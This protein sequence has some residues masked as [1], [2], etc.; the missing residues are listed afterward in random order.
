M[1]ALGISGQTVPGQNSPMP[2]HVS[3]SGHSTD[4][5]WRT[6]LPDAALLS[7][8]LRRNDTANF[9]S[10]GIRT[11]ALRPSFAVF[12]HH[13]EPELEAAVITLAALCRRGRA[14]WRP[15]RW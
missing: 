5:T 1:S 11:Q 14:Q 12:D 6:P 9:G 15:M 2:R 8:V 10:E 3:E 7:P 4:H 13:P